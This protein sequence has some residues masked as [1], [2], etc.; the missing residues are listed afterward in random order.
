MSPDKQQAPVP[1]PGP[2][3]GP[4]RPESGPRGP[5]RAQQADARRDPE[6]LRENQAR[7]GVGPEHKTDAMKKGRRGTFP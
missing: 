6:R 2:A 7:L 5:R 3:G 1:A 4:R